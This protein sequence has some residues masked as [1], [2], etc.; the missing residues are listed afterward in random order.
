MGPARAH[1][2]TVKHYHDMDLI[3]HLGCKLLC[4]AISRVM[5]SKALPFQL[6]PQ[7]KTPIY[8]DCMRLQYYV[9]AWFARDILEQKTQKLFCNVTVRWNSVTI[10]IDW[11]DSWLKSFFPPAEHG[12]VGS[13]ERVQAIWVLKLERHTGV[14]E[15]SA[16]LLETTW[17]QNL[18]VVKDTAGVT[19][20]TEMRLKL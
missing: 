15:A 16:R 10:Q 2:I 3:N 17:K 12:L 1:V 7:F 14:Y 5:P 13:I 8:G 11:R 9:A 4:Q 18:N 20:N 6:R 19:M